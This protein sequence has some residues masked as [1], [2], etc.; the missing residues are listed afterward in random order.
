MDLDVLRS[1][2]FW[3]IENIPVKKNQAERRIPQ[4]KRAM[5]HFVTN[6]NHFGHDNLCAKMIHKFAAVARQK[7]ENA[8]ETTS[9][10]VKKHLTE[11]EIE[12]VDLPFQ[13]NADYCDDAIYKSVLRFTEDHAK[14]L[15]VALTGDVGL[16]RRINNIER[17]FD[18]I[19]V[20]QRAGTR[21]TVMQR[22]CDKIKLTNERD[23]P[24]AVY[25]MDE[26]IRKCVS[27]GVPLTFSHLLRLKNLRGLAEMPLDDDHFMSLFK[28]NEDPADPDPTVPSVPSIEI[29]E[30]TIPAGDD[31]GYDSST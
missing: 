5:Q 4:I 17:D 30:K 13:S 16:V 1:G 9:Q 21:T 18:L 29:L 3:D 7:G 31:S 11:N 23:R 24:L 28:S 14:S 25:F 12:L 27:G 10:V 2:V 22:H 20:M 26:V 19:V 15:V 8:I 6:V